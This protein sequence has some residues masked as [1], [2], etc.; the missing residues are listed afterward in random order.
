MVYR[1]GQFL[2]RGLLDDAMSKDSLERENDLAKILDRAV[3]CSDLLC[4]F[5][6][7]YDI[8]L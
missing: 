1:R 7:A 2:E 4:R 6:S 3:S 8:S 5:P